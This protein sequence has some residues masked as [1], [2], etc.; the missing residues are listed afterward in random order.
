MLEQGRLNRTCRSSSFEAE[1]EQRYD[2]C[3]VLAFF[4]EASMVLSQGPAT[5]WKSQVTGCVDGGGFDA[6]DGGLVASMASMVAWWRR[7]VASNGGNWGLQ[8]RGH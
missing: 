8:H 2:N 3:L 1:C 5:M 7:M 4:A 6:V